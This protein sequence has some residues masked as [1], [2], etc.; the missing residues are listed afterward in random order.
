MQ[1][2]QDKYLS[3][4][5]QRAVSEFVRREV[6]YCVSH[7]VSELAQCPSVYD[8]EYSEDLMAVL[9]PSRQIAVEDQYRLV[10]NLD[11]RGEV[12]VSVYAIDED[13][14]DG[15]EVWHLPPTA[16]D[17]ASDLDGSENFDPTDYGCVLE[18]LIER[19]VIPHS[20]VI[21]G[22]AAEP[23]MVD[24]DSAEIF[25]HWIVTGWLAD[26]LEEKGEAVTRDLLGLTV[27]GRAT[28]GQAISIDR[29]ICDIYDEAHA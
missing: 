13:G 5:Y 23:E 20:S 29:V 16:W 22:A 10:V 12:G 4:D 3:A 17:E 11:E 26:R 21:L 25:E 1:A 9:Y 15:E 28:T 7:L 18:Y 2:K 14:K 6:I 19:K 27:W 24:D 8:G